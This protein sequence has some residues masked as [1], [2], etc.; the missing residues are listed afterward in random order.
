MPTGRLNAWLQLTRLSNAPTVVSNAL[1]GCAIGAAAA[2]LDGGEYPWRAFGIAAP[3][4]VLIYAAGMAT[5][6]AIDVDVDRK[7]RPGRPIPSGR[8]GRGAALV[9]A[10]SAS[11]GALV[12]LWFAGLA[13][14]LCGTGLVAC[15]LLYNLVHARRPA[16]VVLM[17]GCRALSLLTAAAAVGWPPRWDYLAPAAWILW[18]YIIVLSLVARGEARGEA[19]DRT[20]V[21]V[22]V[23][24]VCAI[25]L[26][27]AAVLV[28]LHRGPQAAIA[29]G[30]F[31]L[32][33]MGQRRVLGT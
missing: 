3:A 19:G 9:F 14:C 23:T 33:I 26:I 7:E 29:V 21:R 6:D 20:R 16:S 4:L 18:V 25:S 27:D 32:A 24:M 10:L 2:T 12:L 15:A 8:I 17:G 30:C 11:I 1:T 5:N 22:V 31:L 13:A 28:L